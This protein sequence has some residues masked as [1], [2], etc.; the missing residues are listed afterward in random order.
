MAEVTDARAA[1][2]GLRAGTLVI[3]GGGDG[4]CAGAGIGMVAPGAAYL[5]LG[6]A[7]VSGSYGRAYVH[8]PAFRTEVAVADEGYIFETCLRAGTFLVDW[9]MRELLG[10]APARQADFTRLLEQEAALS[11][12]G[13]GGV[14]LVPY[15]QGCMNPYWDSAA[16]GVIAG[17]SGS[18]RRGDI[19]PAL[20]E[21]IAFEQAAACDRVEAATRAPID[22]LVIVRRCG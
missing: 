10:T 15:W 7:V 8:D 14:M 18:T 12:I 21:G 1:A 11:P 13:A 5:N 4:Q 2:T 9:F 6:T 20:L 3:A 19:Y 17:L 22:H 16:R